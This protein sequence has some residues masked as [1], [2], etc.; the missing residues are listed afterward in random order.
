MQLVKGL[1]R[2][3]QWLN[4][5]PGN[6]HMPWVWPEKKSPDEKVFFY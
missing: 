6:F 3:R 1:A 2:L 5:W 4:P